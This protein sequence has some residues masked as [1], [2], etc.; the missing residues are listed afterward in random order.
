MTC[1]LWLYSS[2]VYRDELGLY[3]VEVL[4][5]KP[6]AA[7]IAMFDISPSNS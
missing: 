3:V 7:K 5:L 2:Y 6:G 1:H 4:L